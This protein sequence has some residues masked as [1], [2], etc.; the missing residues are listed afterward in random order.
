MDETKLA[1]FKSEFTDYFN[2]DFT[3]FYYVLTHFLL[4]IDSRAKN[5]MMATWDDIH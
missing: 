3:L 2:L 5:M 4:M 1:Q